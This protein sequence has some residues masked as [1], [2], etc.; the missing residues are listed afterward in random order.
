MN[1][2]RSPRLGATLMI[3]AAMAWPAPEAT[4]Q[5]KVHTLKLSHFIPAVHQQ[6][7]TFV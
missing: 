5:D 1:R 6:H 2:I 3:V 7:A 4:A